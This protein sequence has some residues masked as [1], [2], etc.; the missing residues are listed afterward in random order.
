MDIIIIMVYPY[1]E[2]AFA[3]IYT[4]VRIV[5][6]KFTCKRMES[7]IKPSIVLP[8]YFCFCV[9]IKL[10]CNSEYLYIIYLHWFHSIFVYIRLPMNV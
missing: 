9:Q 7:V 10:I 5:N 2:F 4:Y 1:F 3:Y 8:S 6:L